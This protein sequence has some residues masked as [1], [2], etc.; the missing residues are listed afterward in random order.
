MISF[1]RVAWEKE[2]G[3]S[4]G[5]TIKEGDLIRN[6]LAKCRTDSK[7][8]AEV[9]RDLKPPRLLLSRNDAA[10]KSNRRKILH[11][12]IFLLHLGLRS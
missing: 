6:Q 9:Q 5:Q 2:R 12:L 7:V 8:L 1:N 3:E 10:S 11:Y 4:I